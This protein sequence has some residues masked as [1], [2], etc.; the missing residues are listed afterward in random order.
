MRQR[1]KDEKLWPENEDKNPILETPMRVLYL[2]GIV[3][4]NPLLFSSVSLMVVT[5]LSL[6]GAVFLTNS[7]HVFDKFRHAINWREEAFVEREPREFDR[8]IASLTGVCFFFSKFFSPCVT[9][10]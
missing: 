5:M 8:M 1:R 2:L 4:K 10:Q 6:T 7:L 3:C 9:L